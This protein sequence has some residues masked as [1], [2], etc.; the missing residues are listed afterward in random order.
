VVQGAALVLYDELVHP[1]E[2]SWQELEEVFGHLDLEMLW[3]AFP[4]NY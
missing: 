3:T 4:L 2:A 1:D